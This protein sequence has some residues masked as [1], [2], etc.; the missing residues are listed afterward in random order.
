MASISETQETAISTLEA[1]LDKLNPRN[2]KFATDLVRKGQ[3]WSL[4]DK[5]MFYVNKFVAEVSGE[6]TES[7]SKPTPA[8]SSTEPIGE[9]V[10][11]LD[12]LRPYLSHQGIPLRQANA[13]CSQ[14]D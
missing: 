11:K 14:D 2:L 6:A 9:L 12:S 10:D 7:D 1:G 4:S 13:I 5:Q 3:K 8:P